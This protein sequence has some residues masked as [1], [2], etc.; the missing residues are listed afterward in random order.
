MTTVFIA[1]SI[2]ISKLHHLV[3][4]RIQK[5]IDGRLD[6][7]VGDADGADTSIQQ[8][9]TELGAASV[10]VYCSGD[11]PRN[12]IGRWPVKN[13]YPKAAPG[14]RAFY[15]AKDVEMSRASDYG[16]MI[17]DCKSTGTLSNVI[18]LINQQKKS[19][20]FV[21][22]RQ[23][24][25]T[26]SDGRSLETLLSF[27]SDHARMK[28]D[29]KIGLNSKISSL[30]Q[31]AFLLDDDQNRKPSVTPEATP[32]AGHDDQQ[33]ANM[34]LRMALIQAIEAHVKA[35]GWTQ[36]EAARMLGVTQPRM[37]DLIRHKASVF[38]LDSL[39]NMVEAAGLQIEV[40]VAA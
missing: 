12:N 28:A 39:V 17:W 16:L 35:Q 40:R 26:V 34:K 11:R 7:V 2:A 38:G 8:C 30:A 21:N 10:T 19:V 22:K 1:G 37:S 25:V 32:D 36:A 29:E 3:K 33:A 27:M 13:I 5:I 4:E 15:T 23:E 6:V 20:V 24:F 9:L 31:S 18:E 14:S